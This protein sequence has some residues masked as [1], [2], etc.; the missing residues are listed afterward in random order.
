M[1]FFPGLCFAFVNADWPVLTPTSTRFALIGFSSSP[2]KALLLHD[3]TS[4]SLQLPMLTVAELNE[5]LAAAG[6]VVLETS[7]APNGNGEMRAPSM[8]DRVNDFVGHG[9]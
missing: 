2:N 7:R 1:R 3:G 4:Q 5:A 8:R 6:Y 9:Y